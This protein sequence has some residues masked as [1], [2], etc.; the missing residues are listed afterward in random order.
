M[1]FPGSGALLH[2][3][4]RLSEYKAKAPYTVNELLSAVNSLMGDEDMT[5]RT[6][7]Y[8]VGQGVLNRP[9]GAP[10][11]AR[12]GYE[13]LVCIL[14]ARML[15]DRGW[16]LDRITQELA[17]ARGG[18]PDA[19]A[20][21]VEEW[22]PTRV[23][24]ERRK[25]YGTGSNGSTRSHNVHRFVLTEKSAIEIS[26]NTELKKELLDASKSLQKLVKS[27]SE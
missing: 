1:N 2:M 16:K 3:S 25:P 13:H 5:V 24:R 12:Y 9:Y 27:L 14:A 11:F 8:Y 7:R 26:A 4:M 19:Y 21:H 15:Q 6:I 20:K 17:E 10:K 22:L 18:Q 23:V